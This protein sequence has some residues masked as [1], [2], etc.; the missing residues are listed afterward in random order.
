MT[1][2][3]TEMRYYLMKESIKYSDAYDENFDLFNRGINILE[4][5]IKHQDYSEFTVDER[6]TLEEISE[7]ME[8]F[9]I[10]KDEK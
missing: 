5:R 3:T 2:I 8:T 1:V 10:P 7:K 9:N 6:T 4:E